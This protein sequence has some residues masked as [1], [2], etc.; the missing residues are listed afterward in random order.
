MPPQPRLL[1]AGTRLAD[2]A[3]RGTDGTAVDREFFAGP[4]VVGVFSTSCPACRER[5]PEFTQHVAGTARARVL[6]VV[7]GEVDTADELVTT[8]QQVATV[9]REPLG[10]PLVAAFDVN[11]FPTFFLIERDGVVAGAAVKPS[12]LRAAAPV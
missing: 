5:L 6:A 1:P 3:A 8:L 9:V 4:T 11:A 10:G 12:D 2:F 7:A